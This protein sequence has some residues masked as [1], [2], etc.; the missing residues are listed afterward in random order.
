MT[1]TI[2]DRITWIT[3]PRLPMLLQS[4]PAENSATCLAMISA[5]HG[6][7]LDLTKLI[8]ENHTSRHGINVDELM[9][10]ASRL[11]FA[12]RLVHA[13]D[14]D[15][16][17][18]QLPCILQWAESHF[19]VLRSIRNGVATVHDPSKGL[20][21]VS[22]HDLSMAYTG[23]AIELTPTHDFS[24]GDDTQRLT[25][26]HFWTASNGISGYLLKVLVLSVFLQA[27]TLLVPFYL[28]LVIDESVIRRDFT[29]LHLL[30]LVFVCVAVLQA[31]LTWFRS[32]AHTYL[33]TIIGIQLQT[34]LIR[35]LLLL[36]MSFFQN[37][38]IGDIMARY[39]SMTSVQGFLSNGLQAV[40]ADVLMVSTTLVA[41]LLYHPMLALA[42]IVQLVIYSIVRSFRYSAQRR[43]SNENIA[44]LAETNSH[45]VET[46]RSMSTIKLHCFESGRLNLWAN[47]NVD[48]ANS[49]LRLARINIGFAALIKLISNMGTIAVV[50]FGAQL[51]IDGSL[52]IGMLIAFMSYQG[53]FVSTGADLVDQF[54]SYKLLSVSLDRIGGIALTATEAHESF[55]AETRPSSPDYSLVASDIYFRHPQAEKPILQGVNLSVRSGESLAIIG[56]SGVGKSTLIRILLSLETATSGKVLFSGVDIQR[57]GLSYYRSR[58]AAVTQEDRLL[59]GTILENITMFDSAPN[60]DRAREA[61]ELVDL[62]SLVDTMPLGMRSSVGEGGDTLSAGER[63][64]LLL[65]RAIYKRPRILFLDEATSNLDLDL[66]IKIN[67][68]LINLNM[69]RIV[70][71]HRKE[72]LS[73][74]DRIV[75]L[76]QGILIHYEHPSSPT[77]HDV[78]SALSTDRYAAV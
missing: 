45:F 8:A 77:T 62:S 15:L 68:A 31:A 72:P 26:R 58:I 40:L 13:S 76:N 42:S 22:P 48:Q 21:V 20:K 60:W 53:H 6:R 14:A 32:W 51:I 78:N 55:S 33:S 50:Y 63:Q 30:T 64:R 27:L 25:L 23:V 9:K 67:K 54:N 66:D 61:V 49:G 56:P 29:L 73:F 71:T 4:A 46:A 37:R 7:R 34:S 59:S 41:M 35:H 16:P 43:L 1:A 12:P 2:I 28:Q 39:S 65:A 57:L 17:N 11:N 5:F 44:A 70:V 38:P 36:P 19:V 74:V 3:K 10:L 52:S 47:R 18:L 69:S 24:K 75:E